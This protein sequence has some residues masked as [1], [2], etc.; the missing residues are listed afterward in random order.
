MQMP[1]RSA[2]HS[3]NDFILGLLSRGRLRGVAWELQTS[4]AEPAL[5]RWHLL[6]A[7]AG[8][9]SPPWRSPEE[10]LPRVPPAAA[11]AAGT[12]RTATRAGTARDPSGAVPLLNAPDGGSGRVGRAG[13]RAVS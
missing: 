8:R 4:A 13:G 11:N 1:G 10:S 5:W 9:R 12:G 7:P 3:L 2:D 6:P